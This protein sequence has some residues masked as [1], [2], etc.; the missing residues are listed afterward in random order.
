MNT[1]TM[2]HVDDKTEVREIIK[3]YADIFPE[4][5]VDGLSPKRRH[6]SSIKLTDDAQPRCSGKYLLAQWDLVA[7]RARWDPGD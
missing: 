6:S 4:A 2:G 5:L 1:M 7:L 3:E